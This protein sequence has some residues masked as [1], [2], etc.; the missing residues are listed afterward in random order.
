MAG[1]DV[2]ER[3]RSAGRAF[4]AAGVGSFLLEQGEGPAVVCV[5]GVPSS[6]FLYRKLLPELAQRGL[7][8]LA[9]D[10][11]GLGLADRP[12][13][14]D[15]TWTGL[16]RWAATAI[17]VLGLDAFHLVV[18][19]IGGPVGF[20]VA[21]AMPDRVR[22]VTILNTM[23]EVDGF[24]RPWMM[25]PFARRGIGRAYVATMSGPAF[26]PLFRWTGLADRKAV[27]N[28]EI[29]AYVQLLK[30]GD[31][32]RAFLKIM[33]GFERTR[34]KQELYVGT[35]SAARFPVQAVWGA[36]DPTLTMER[37]GAAVKRITGPVHF[38][39][40]TGKHFVPEEQSPAI[41]E[42][43]AHIADMPLADTLEHEVRGL[44]PDS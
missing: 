17:D 5:H 20:E 10:L 36:Q 19:D 31:G 7:R 23:V 26:R 30:R 4:D 6:S 24:K 41:A 28:E 27:P 1:R 34:E 32:G 29:D 3:H 12:E 11:P 15:Y 14:F 13:A 38:H 9:F 35:L 16:G 42:H 8:G 21:A 44:R 25:E 2:V 40:V 18:H 37:E 22:S 43:V 39:P 33:R